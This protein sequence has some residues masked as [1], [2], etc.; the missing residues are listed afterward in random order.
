M[1]LVNPCLKHAIAAIPHL[2]YARALLWQ[3]CG[4]LRML[5]ESAKAAS[6][7]DV[8][9]H[10]RGLV[11]VDPAKSASLFL[12]AT[13]FR[14][15]STKKLASNDPFLNRHKEED[16]SGPR[17]EPRKPSMPTSRAEK[18]P[19]AS[20]KANSFGRVGGFINSLAQRTQKYKVNL[21]GP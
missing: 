1:E 12:W 5:H 18:L 20:R 11:A 19:D 14:P 6:S 16:P 3:P 21:L 17:R 10:L 15:A 7:G 2:V 8:D 13:F 4:N 9:K